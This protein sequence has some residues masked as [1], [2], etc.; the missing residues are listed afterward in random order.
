[1]HRRSIEGQHLV[2]FHDSFFL[3]VE[4]IPVLS[5]NLNTFIFVKIHVYIRYFACSI[6]SLDSWLSYLRTRESVLQ[7]HYHPEAFLYHANTAT[8]NLYDDLLSALRPLALMPLHLDLLYEYKIL[9]ASLLKMEERLL[10]HNSSSTAQS[11][12]ERPA[13]V[14]LDHLL[15]TKETKEFKNT[16]A[17][18]QDRVKALMK[19]LTSPEATE[20]DLLQT[21]ASSVSKERSK[22]PRPRSCYE[23]AVPDA[24]DLHPALKKRW[25]NVQ[26][27]SK[28]IT[29]IDKLMLEETAGASGSSGDFTDSIDNPKHRLMCSEE[30]NV[31]DLRIS[32][33]SNRDD[34]ISERSATDKDT[35]NEKGHRICPTSLAY[36]KDQE[37]EGEKFRRLQMKWERMAGENQKSSNPIK[38]YDETSDNVCEMAQ[39]AAA[40]PA[41][42]QVTTK[43]PVVSPSQTNRDKVVSP[44]SGTRSRIPR[45]VSMTSPQR[46]FKPF[47]PTKEKTSPQIKPPMHTRPM[48]GTS[49]IVKDLPKPAPRRS[50]KDKTMEKQDDHRPLSVRSRVGAKGASAAVMA[51]GNRASSMPGRSD[52]SDRTGGRGGMAHGHGASASGGG[53]GGRYDNRRSGVTGAGWPRS[54]SQGRRLVPGIVPR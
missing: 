54:A 5:F 16:A 2:L 13:S 48:G 31:T 33:I 25:S 26:L 51:T 35:E 21:V 52:S 12:I 43:T 32:D 41:S 15:V 44:S 50:L 39:N 6:R 38:T 46:P 29:A 14:L 42:A 17:A 11:P 24:D 7:K 9:H 22:S 37:S 10:M 4:S 53:S 36:C 28:L 23:N 19:V 27:G 3:C 47:E 49:G 34:D 18:Q 8:R 30:D 1:M 20:A 45:P 40:S